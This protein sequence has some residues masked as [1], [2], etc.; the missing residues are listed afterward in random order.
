M[1]TPDFNRLSVD[2]LLSMREIINEIL[3]SKIGEER[4]NLELRM[5]TL[6]RFDQLGRP[7]T[8]GVSKF[9]KIPAK[10]QNP[11][12]PAE[13]WAGRGKTPRWLA[14]ALKRGKKKEE[15][16]IANPHSERFPKSR[17]R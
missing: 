9:A 13:T 15:F 10:Y 17:R 5:A 2:E 16:L 6:N 12:N 7:F 1:K 3:T 8:D 14:A 11:E 4:R